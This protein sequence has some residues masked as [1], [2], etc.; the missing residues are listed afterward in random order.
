MK[1]L[2][3]AAT[4]M[5]SLLTVS[6]CTDEVVV[7]ELAGADEVEP[8]DGKGDTT[9]GG[10]STYYEISRDMRKCTFPMCSGFFLDRL[11]AS[12]TKCHDGTNKEQCYTPEL[13][14]SESGLSTAAYDKLAEMSAQS[15]FSPGV[16]AIVRGRFAKKNL[17][18][19]TPSL[20]RFIVTEVW[21][22]QSEAVSS[23]VFAKVMDNGI[24]CIAAP[25]PSTVEKALNTSRTAN[26]VEIDFSTS[27]VP[28]SVLEEVG[29]DMF[30]PHGVI[31]AGERYTAHFQGRS[32]KGRTA[33]AVYRRMQETNDAA[34]FVGGC[35]GQVCSDQEGVITTCEFRPEYACYHDA[36][37]ERQGDGQCGW[38]ATAAL[39]T[40]LG[41]N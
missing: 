15:T 12:T 11:N 8:A 9:D 32:G 5:V 28:D 34:C 6:A 39:N 25:C 19:P 24:R 7:D 1:N 17:T 13:D 26:I 22:S 21:L 3:I 35:S 38:T 37:C 18:T 10:T 31:I 20:G 23:G 40:C 14:M 36:T 27:Q 29:N 30:E 2:V 16:R 33:T 4:A 41:N